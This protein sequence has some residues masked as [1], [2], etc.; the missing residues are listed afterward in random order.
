[1]N[2]RLVVVLAPSALTLLVIGYALARSSVGTLAPGAGLQDGVADLESPLVLVAVPVSE[3]PEV[4]GDYDDEEWRDAPVLQV[5]AIR[6][7]A[8]Y[9]DEHIAFLMKWID[10]DLKMSS[11]GCWTWDPE[12]RFWTELGTDRQEWLDLAWD[13]SS[14]MRNRGCNSFCHED[15]PGSG[16]FHHQTG[17]V[18]EY[19]DSWMIFGKHGYS[20]PKVDLGWF[21]GESGFRVEEALIFETTNQADPRNV[22]AGDVTFFGYAEDSVIAAAG[23]PRFAPRDRPRDGYCRGCHAE[24]H[25]EGD[26]LKLNFTHPDEGEIK[27]SPNWNSAHTAPIYMET[28]PG[29]FVD[30]MILTQEEVDDGQAAAVDG[31]SEEQVSQYWSRYAALNGAVPPLVL[32]TPTGSMADV[33]VA[34]NWTDGLWTV[35]IARK[36]VTGDPDD[37]QFFDLNKS[38]PFCVSIS[39]FEYLLDEKLWKQPGLLRFDPSAAPRDRSLEPR[40]R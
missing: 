4:D 28:A 13:I 2:R 25:V 31:L 24:L 22:L 33:R 35:E 23:D 27:Y 36:R 21:L 39:N 15:P 26:P 14:A 40:P 9:T 8:V 29:N 10:R 7:R 12:A 3:L 38:Y 20:A 37:V 17:K 34:A 11:T 5:G 19:V 30:C 32:K 18:G 16:E 6:F 1:M